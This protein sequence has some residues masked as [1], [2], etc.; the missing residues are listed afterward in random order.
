MKTGFTQCGYFLL[1]KMDVNRRNHVKIV[2]NI[3]PDLKLMD[4][5]KMT[6]KLKDV[7]LRSQ[8]CGFLTVARQS[9]FAW[10]R[11]W[12]VLD[13]T[14]LKIWNT[15]QDVDF[16][17]PIEILYFDKCVSM[18]VGSANRQFCPK[19]RTLLLEFLFHGRENGIQQYFLNTDNVE[20]YEKWDAGF[21]EMVTFLHTW[22]I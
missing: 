7:E 17:D 11:R 22:K 13:G 6:T 14:I 18:T 10:E 9:C 16:N 12:C 2:T 4:A 15:P 1:T 8:I 3:P 21:N 20:D 5:V 19:P